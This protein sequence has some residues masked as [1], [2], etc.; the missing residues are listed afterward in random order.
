MGEVCFANSAMAKAEEEAQSSQQL[1][2]DAVGQN[3]T[4]YIKWERAKAMK[5]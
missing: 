1:L 5:A 2:S 3:G 4:W